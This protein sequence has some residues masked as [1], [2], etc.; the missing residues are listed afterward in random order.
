VAVE[1]P[2]W[3][4]LNE[5]IDVVLYRPHL[6]STLAVALVVGTIFFMINQLDVVLDDKATD[7]TW[8]KAGI[9]YI[10]PF[11]VSNYGVLAAT[12]ERRPDDSDDNGGDD[13]NDNG[14]SRDTLQSEVV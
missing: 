12:Y 7:M 13:S 3:S 9:T 5:I 6:K 11:A 4:C 14:G 10:V 1:K 8:V 2:T